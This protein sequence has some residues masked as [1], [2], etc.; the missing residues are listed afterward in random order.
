LIYTYLALLHHRDVLR[1]SLT[2]LLPRPGKN[3]IQ[4]AQS[5]FFVLLMAFPLRRRHLFTLEPEQGH[6]LVPL[7]E[8]AG[9]FKQDTSAIPIV[10][11][12]IGFGFFRPVAGSTGDRGRQSL[13]IEWNGYGWDRFGAR[14]RYWRRAL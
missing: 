13:R 5:G 7:L 10:E 3:A 12:D 9:V 4:F 1:G 6:C 14:A 8:V 11:P 2:A